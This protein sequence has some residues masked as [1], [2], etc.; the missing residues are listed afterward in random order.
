MKA[1]KSFIDVYRKKIYLFWGGCK[2]QE[3]KSKNKKYNIS[4]EIADELY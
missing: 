3:G 1:V 2:K 4:N